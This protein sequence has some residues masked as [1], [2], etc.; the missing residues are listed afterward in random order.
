MAKE[1]KPSRLLFI[2][3]LVNNKTFIT[4]FSSSIS[5]NITFVLRIALDLRSGYTPWRIRA[6]YHGTES[7]YIV[8]STTERNGIS[9]LFYA[10]HISRN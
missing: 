2:V 8:Y 1:N 5:Q 4:S 3:S 6:E 7:E 9:V 10:V